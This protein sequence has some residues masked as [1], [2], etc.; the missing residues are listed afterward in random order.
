MSV[1]GSAVGG[2]K[3]RT[4]LREK[5]IQEYLRRIEA[6]VGVCVRE[7]TLRFTRERG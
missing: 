7:R 5:V 1:R 3:R 4:R 6:C 2:T